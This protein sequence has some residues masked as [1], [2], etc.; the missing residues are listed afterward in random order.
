MQAEDRAFEA[1]HVGDRVTFTVMVSEEAVHEFAR[2][3]GDLNPL[4]TD[5]LYASTTE[6]GSTIV[7][8]MLLGAFVSRLV[9]MHLPGRRCL[10]LSATFDFIGPVHPG[11]ELEVSGTVSRRQ[12]A[13]RS[14]LISVEIRVAGGSVVVKAKVLVKVL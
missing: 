2:L 5:P 3:S 10:L 14:L 12:E 4:H 7:H 1:I 13:L 9:G 8:G 11:Q 6:F